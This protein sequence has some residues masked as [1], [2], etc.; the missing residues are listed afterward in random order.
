MS[1]LFHHTYSAA[2]TAAVPADWTHPAA[3]LK[4]QR[5]TRPHSPLLPPPPRDI[6]GCSVKLLDM[7]RRLTL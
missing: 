3:Q 5:N 4:L 2:L 6:P 7:C 1:E